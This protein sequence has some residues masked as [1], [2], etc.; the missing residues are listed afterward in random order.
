M[1]RGILRT[2]GMVVLAI[3][4]LIL[5]FLILRSLGALHR[6]GF[7]FLTTQNFFPE[8]AISSASRAHPARLGS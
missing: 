5:V 8:P 2:A 3:T 4:L 1:F 6:A 7:V